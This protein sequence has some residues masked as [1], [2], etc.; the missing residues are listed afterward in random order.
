MGGP[1]FPRYQLVIQPVYL[2]IATHEADMELLLDNKKLATSKG[3]DY[4]NHS[5][6]T[7]GNYQVIGKLDNEKAVATQQLIRY[8]NPKFE[9][10]S[11][12]TINLHKIS[13]KVTSNIDGAK[14]LLNDKEVGTIQNGQ[15]EIK[16]VVWH[17]KD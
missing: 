3:H 6:L 17:Q 12:V 1:V 9:T 14:V 4:Q 10:D 15:A 8:H 5:G 7:P 13:F 16:D 2:T 11:H